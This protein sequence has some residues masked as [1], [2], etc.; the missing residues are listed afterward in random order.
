MWLGPSAFSSA[1]RVFTW[2]SFLML[3][4]LLVLPVVARLIAEVRLQFSIKH[5]SSRDSQHESRKL[6]KHASTEGD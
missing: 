6:A 1:G 4:K 3:C 2:G 5:R